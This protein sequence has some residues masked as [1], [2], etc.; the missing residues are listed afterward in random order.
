MAHREPG[1][2]VETSSSIGTGDYE[3]LGA[4]EAFEA[5]GDRIEDGST[6]VVIVTPIDGGGAWEE[7]LYTFN[8][9][10]DSLARTQIYGSSNG[11]AAVDWGP[12]IRVLK[13]TRPGMS[14]L[15]AAGL[16]RHRSLLGLGALDNPQFATIN[17]G[18]ASDTTISRVSA[19]V[20]AVE[21]SNILLASGL[22]TITQAYDSDLAAIAAL[23]TTAAGRSILTLADPNEDRFAMWDDSAGAFV[24]GTLGT[25]LL[26]SGTSLAVDPSDNF[27]FTEAQTIT[28]S[29]AA[30]AALSLISTHAGAV[31]AAL[32][33]LHNSA[34]PAMWDEVGLFGFY[35]KNAAAET[36]EYGR[37][38][39]YIV[40]TTDG[41]EDGQLGLSVILAGS[42]TNIA[43]LNA[44]GMG[45]TGGL[46][47]SGTISEGGTQLSAKYQGLDADL[48]AIGALAK[49]DG[50]IIVGNGSTWVAESGATART[51]LGVAI[52]SDVQAYDA[53]LAAVAALTTT[54]AGRSV[55]VFADPNADR[56]MGWDDSVGGIVGFT[57]GTGLSFTASP[58]LDLEAGLGAI[59]ALAKTDGNIIVGDGSTWVAES[60]ATARTSL[61]LGTGNAVEFAAIKG[62]TLRIESNAPFLV[63][64][65]ADAAANEKYFD[66]LRS[67][68]DLF[69]RFG[70]DDGSSLVNWL[71]VF[72]TGTT[73][74]LLFS[75]S[76][77]ELDGDFDLDGS[78]DVLGD[79]V[80]NGAIAVTG[81]FSATGAAAGLNLRDA[82][83]QFIRT[84]TTSTGNVDHF[85]IF[86]PN[87]QVGSARSN[88]GGSSWVTT[89]DERLKDFLPDYF[90]PERAIE[91]ILADPVR[92]WHWKTSGYYDVGWGA[93]TSFAIAE[94]L[95]LPTFDFA[96]EGVGDPGDEDFAP[97]GMAQG[98]RTPYLWAAVT[99]LINK[100]RALEAARSAA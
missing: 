70:A 12:G 87:G 41:S 26:F 52:G 1:R 18:H 65:E 15:D 58:S 69:F 3:L 94:R 16:A 76:E 96:S 20:L 46:T 14:D 13:A 100:V 71:R 4:V 77:I 59:S 97:W 22:G 72:A 19:G 93:Q 10:A 68:G 11:G 88:A 30:T 91:A 54:A 79:W 98:D 7:G 64:Y 48:T 85:A 27:A 29:S 39:A 42:L 90:D 9:G 55:L 74:A 89:S 36:V 33:F 44:G 40:D 57:L 56:L 99:Y 23:T 28:V 24:M 35:G 95:G 82:A 61:G 81:D 8:A 80:V 5:F 86:N 2:V 50:N 49:T 37:V 34:S 60:G 31:G 84:S 47:I 43:V 63:M 51:S 66:I 38:T 17:I 78:G 6:V 45:V 73:A 32:Q 83:N 21:G 67:G 25:G 75:A 53:D 92:H 62:T